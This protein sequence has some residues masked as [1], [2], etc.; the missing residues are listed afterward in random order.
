MK[1][2]KST[3]L[4]MA[5]VCLAGANWLYAQS[6]PNEYLGLPGDNLNLYAVMDVFQTSETIEA[7]ERNLNDPDKLINNLDLNGDNLVDYIMV[8]DYVDDNTHTIV[9]RV[10]LNKREQQDVAVFTVQQFNDGSVQVQLIGDE[11]LYGPNY[12]I[13]PIYA[14]TPNPGYTGNAYQTQGNNVVTTT[15]HEVANWPVVIYLYAPIYRP[16][17]SAWYWGYYPPYWRPWSPHYWHFYYGYHSHW[18]GHYYAYY[19]PWRYYRSDR[20]RN[21]YVARIRNSSPTVAVNISSG[22]YRDTYGKPERRRDGENLFTQKYPNGAPRP[23]RQRL[24]NSSIGRERPNSNQGVSTNG[25][26][27]A[28]Q[29]EGLRKPREAQSSSREDMGRSRQKGES[30]AINY[31]P[32]R[33]EAI[34]KP[35]KQ[36]QRPARGESVK[37]TR[38]PQKPAR[39]ESARPKRDKVSKPA[40]TTRQS[41]SK[42][43]KKGTRERTEKRK[44]T[45]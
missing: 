43:E 31:R 14:E 13:E 27:P 15:Y 36:T 35:T 41:G 38:Q 16:W 24:D 3:L 28:Q 30:N 7:F 4:V 23:N 9:L 21:V 12:I 1:K 42:Q 45:L 8:Y 39:K 26:R 44:R 10:A 34:S 40:S 32:P 19:R 2:L 11:A 5:L 20:Y 17:S 6:K 22:R 25:K 37:P 33:R 29:S 18:H